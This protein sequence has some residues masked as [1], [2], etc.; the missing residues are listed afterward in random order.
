MMPFKSPVG[1]ECLAP[2]L[3]KGSLASEIMGKLWVLWKRLKEGQRQLLKLLPTSA[4][5]A[6]FHP[7]GQEE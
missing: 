4:V 6:L 3:R 7:L 2:K 5:P 1:E